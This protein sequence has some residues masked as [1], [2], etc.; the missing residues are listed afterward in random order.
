[1]KWTRQALSAPPRF[2]GF[3]QGIYQ[4]SPY[5]SEALDNVHDMVRFCGSQQPK[6]TPEDST[7]S[8]VLSVDSGT[9]ISEVKKDIACCGR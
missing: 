6:T 1:M 9:R 4:A 5:A 3:L 2:D 7:A 8:A